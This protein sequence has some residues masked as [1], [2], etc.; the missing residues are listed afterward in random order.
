M[1]DQKKCGNNS[2]IWDFW[3]TKRFKWTSLGP[4]PSATNGFVCCQSSSW[5]QVEPWARHPRREMINI[6]FGEDS[7]TLQDVFKLIKFD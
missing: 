4:R 7:L 2:K 5:H 1:W 6:C 3:I